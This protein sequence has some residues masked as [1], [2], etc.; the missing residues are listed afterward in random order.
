MLFISVYWVTLTILN[1]YTDN[2]I[3]EKYRFLFT[4]ICSIQTGRLRHY[5][6]EY[7]QF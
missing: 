2:A 3:L 4:F 6:H 7:F 5:R 1:S